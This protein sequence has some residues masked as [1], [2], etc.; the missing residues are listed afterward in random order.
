MPLIHIRN[1]EK[2]ANHPD[3]LDGYEWAKRNF[4]Q[5]WGHLSLKE[6]RLIALVYKKTYRQDKDNNKNAL[7]IARYLSE[8]LKQQEAS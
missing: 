3:C 7:G 6:L 8:H 5:W 1:H 4:Q 2:V